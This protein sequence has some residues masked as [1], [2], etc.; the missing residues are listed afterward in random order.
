MRILACHNYYQQPGGEDQSFAGEAELLADHGHDVTRFT[1]HNDDIAAMGR[2]T[3]AKKTLWNRSV[4]E[5][6]R[7]TIR[8][9]RPDVMHCTNTFPLIS[10][11]AYYA[12]QREGVA[13][14]QSLRNYRLLCPNSLF[15]RK[16]RVCQ[17]CVGRSF[18]WPGVWHA[19]YRDSYA[20]SAVVS[21][22]L[23]LHRLRGTW[24]RAVDRYFA[25]TQ[26]SRQQFIDAGFPAD[27]VA[28]KPNFIDPDPGIGTGGGRYAVFVG[29][30]SP[31]KG[32]G[33]LLAAWREMQETIELRIVGDGPLAAD[34]RAA[35]EQDPRIKW[36]GH[37]AA[38]R[39]LEVVGEAT[40]LIVPS[41]CF[42]GFPRTI[43]EAFAKATPVIASRIGS[44]IELIDDGDTGF[45]FEPGDAQQ[46]R[47]RVV[48]MFG[49][50]D[51]AR[52]MRHAARRRYEDH[53]TASRNYELLM[54][55]YDRALFRRRAGQP[56]T[57]EAN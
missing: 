47:D 24:T 22:M 34:V 40:A 53:Y 16:G 10:P 42:E 7:E 54:D 32:I 14:V 48:T 45:H 5:R 9:A 36:W 31:E 1:E 38:E 33:T 55:I 50:R 37:V 41:I 35:A 4:Y 15:V 27:R 44:M 30:L 51:R 11:A 13:V 19:C 21:A 28:V 49:D 20:A 46:L 2:W 26:F 43:V 17:K 6:L 25:L 8:V 23:G 3:V 56:V 52:R 57:V 12:A 18:A 29:R 39:V